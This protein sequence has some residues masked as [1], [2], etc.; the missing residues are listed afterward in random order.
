MAR[1]NLLAGLLDPAEPNELTAVN[2]PSDAPGTARPERRPAPLTPS[3]TGRGAV[4]AMSR[5][6]ERLTSEVVSARA[7]EDQLKSGSVAVELD[8][9]LVDPSPAP[10]RLPVIDGPSEEA[11][12]A[13]IRAQGQ[14]TPILVRPHPSVS[15]RYQVAFGHRRLRAAAALGRPVR[16]LVKT[17][18]DAELVVAQGQENNA[19]ADLSFIERAAFAL[20]LE[21][22]GH[23]RDVIM[24]ALLVDKTELSRLITARRA[25]PDFVIAAIGPAP[26]AGRRRW[27]SLADRLASPEMQARVTEIVAEEAFATL[28]SDQ[29]FVRVFAA[30]TPVLPATAAGSC[31]ARAGSRS[32]ERRTPLG[33]HRANPDDPG[34]DHR[35]DASSRLRRLPRRAPAGAL[36]GVRARAGA[37]PGSVRRLTSPPSALRFVGSEAAGLAA[38]SRGRGDLA[39]AVLTSIRA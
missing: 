31:G 15:G 16:A 9:N 8:P 36:R 19:R 22:L 29:R 24:A 26:R 21:R 34:S 3:F 23:G 10:D 12:V 5:S 37:R 4:G 38:R 1:K 33:A 17:L 20:T 35:R 27:M 28:N 39:G 13:V 14:Q 18:T 30:V 11:F 25:L 2:S 7:A 6:L 32:G